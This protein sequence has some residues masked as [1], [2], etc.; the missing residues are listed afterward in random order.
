[1]TG[2]LANSGTLSNSGTIEIGN[3]NLTAA[4]TVSVDGLSNTGTI[5]LTGS[6]TVQASLLV[7][8][9]APTTLTGKYFLSGDAELGFETGGITAIGNSAELSL[10]GAKARVA[11]G[12]APHSNSVL[13][14]LGSNV[15]TLRLENGASFNTTVDFLNNGVIDVDDSLSYGGSRLAIG[16]TLT[17]RGNLVIGNG[18]L[19]AATTVTATDLVNAGTIDLTGSGANRGDTRR[20]PR[21]RLRLLDRD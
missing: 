18:A 11:L 3:A 6:A 5:D 20:R 13:T 12:S 16:G 7:E 1:M 17:N 9:A 8:P 14:Q 19:T 10:T 21:L 4:T 2:T 15:G